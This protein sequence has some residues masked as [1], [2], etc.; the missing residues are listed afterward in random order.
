MNTLRYE[1]TTEEDWLLDMKKEMRES[2]KD[3]E[4]F[5]NFSFDEGKSR[6]GK[7]LWELVGGQDKEAD[8]NQ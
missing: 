6:N 1:L 3:K 5:Y 8:L 4:R 2:Q 7:F